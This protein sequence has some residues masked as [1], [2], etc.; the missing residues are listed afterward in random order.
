MSTEGAPD[1]LPELTGVGVVDGVDVEPL[2][3]RAAGDLS[4]LTVR[5]EAATQ[6]AD[7]AEAQAETAVSPYG[8]S[9]EDEATELQRQLQKELAERMALLDTELVRARVEAAE[10]IETARTA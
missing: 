10:M 7:A 9:L 4:S 5:L 3:S 2:L 8:E 1:V 6:R